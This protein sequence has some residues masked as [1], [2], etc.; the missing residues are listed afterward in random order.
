[1]WVKLPDFFVFN[2]RR[3]CFEFS[4]RYLDVTSWDQ[5][6]LDQ[7]FTEAMAKELLQE[8]F[9]QFMDVSKCVIFAARFAPERMTFQIFA[10]SPQ[11]K[12]RFLGC[13]SPIVR[14]GQEL[15]QFLESQEPANGT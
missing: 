6:V 5:D 12:E 2:D 13:E 9:G 3:I 1:M 10:S 15:S 7:A 14:S 4:F 8:K 11:F